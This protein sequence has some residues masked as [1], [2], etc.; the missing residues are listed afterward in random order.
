MKL[1]VLDIVSKPQFG[2]RFLPENK[3]IQILR[4]TLFPLIPA[5]SSHISFY[6]SDNS[7]KLKQYRHQEVAA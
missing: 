5:V 4:R 7:I 2:N 1:F 6:K 3:T